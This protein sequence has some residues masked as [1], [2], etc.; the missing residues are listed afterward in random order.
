MRATTTCN[1]CMVTFLC[2][3][4]TDDAVVFDLVEY[5]AVRLLA[6]AGLL[7]G[8]QHR[9]ADAPGDVASG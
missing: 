8:L 2:D 4:E 7:P 5:R 9:V 1:D 6:D 3:R